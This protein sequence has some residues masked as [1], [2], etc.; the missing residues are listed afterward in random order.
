MI[1]KTSRATSYIL[2]EELHHWFEVYDFS[3]IHN[4]F[5]LSYEMFT[6]HL[7]MEVKEYLYD[8]LNNGTFEV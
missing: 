3:C 4:L 8:L 5:M 1:I 7:S 2:K 6:L